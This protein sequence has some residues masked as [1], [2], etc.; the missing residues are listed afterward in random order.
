MIYDTNCR[1][2]GQI[3]QIKGIVLCKTA[4]ISDTSHKVGGFLGFPYFLS[5]SYKF[6]DSHDSLRFDN[7]LE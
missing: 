5:T 1:G 2:L 6:G 3:S 4:V 7:L